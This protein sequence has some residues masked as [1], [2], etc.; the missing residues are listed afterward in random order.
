MI[1]KYFTIFFQTF[2]IATFY[3]FQLLSHRNNLIGIFP[4]VIYSATS[5]KLLLFLFFVTLRRTCCVF[6]IKK[7]EKNERESA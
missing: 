2:F 7:Y 1:K 6:L 5:I 4:F 3:F